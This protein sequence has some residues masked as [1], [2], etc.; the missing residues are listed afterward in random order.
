MKSLTRWDPFRMMKHWDPIDELRSMQHEMDRLFDRFVG[1]ET[2]GERTG[3]W[4][5]SVESYTKDG[6]LIFKANF[7]V[8]IRKISMSASMTTGN[9]LLRGNERLKRAPRKRTISIE[10]FP[11]VTL[12]GTLCFPKVSRQK[13]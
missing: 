3:L 12:N 9:W 7:L 6:Q 2:A 1:G 8:L 10:R 11:M 5:P 4:M 13:T